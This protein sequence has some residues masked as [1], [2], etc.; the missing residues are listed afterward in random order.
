M[1]LAAFVGQEVGAPALARFYMSAISLLYLGRARAAW[2]EALAPV[3]RMAMS[4]YV[5][6]SLVCALLFHSYGLGLF[7]RTSYA[8]NVLIALG[9]C[10]VQVL[11]SRAWLRRFEYGPLEWVLRAF[12]YQGRPA[13]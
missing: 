4:N 12:V 2:L 9:L 3:G 5:F 11:L 1:Q 8:V 10:V 13:A 6:Q 7:N